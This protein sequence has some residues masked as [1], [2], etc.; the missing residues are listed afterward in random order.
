MIADK[1]LS[2]DLWHNEDIANRNIGR[3]DRSHLSPKKPHII[4][5]VGIPLP[6][7]RARID[8]PGQILAAQMQHQTI[9]RIGPDE[10][11]I[12]PFQFPDLKGF[13]LGFAF[14]PVDQCPPQHLKQLIW[15]A[16]GSTAEEFARCRRHVQSLMILPGLGIRPSS[17]GVCVGMLVSTLPAY[18]A[19]ELPFFVVLV[20]QAGVVH[21]HR[22]E[23]LIQKPNDLRIGEYERTA[24][25]AIVSHASKGMSVHRPDENRLPLPCCLLSTFPEFSEP[26][27]LCPRFL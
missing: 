1:P 3:N 16:C 26:I 17:M 24:R 5:I 13:K 15:I 2:H 9:F 27:H 14:I 18:E 25:D 23:S 22:H 21:S 4:L 11:W 7:R 19:Q 12:A 8:L 20:L 6:V 10:F